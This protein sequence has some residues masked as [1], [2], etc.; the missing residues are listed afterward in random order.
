M[1]NT[2]SWLGQLTCDGPMFPVGQAAPPCAIIWDCAAACCAICNKKVTGM[3]A[4]DNHIC[5]KQIQTD[6][7]RTLWKSLDDYKADNCS[8][9]KSRAKYCR[10]KMHKYNH[11]CWIPNCRYYR[12]IS[13]EFQAWIWV[14]SEGFQCITQKSCRR[15]LIQIL[16]SLYDL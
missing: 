7:R 4:N 5:K 12:R 2:Q 13:V 11:S 1:H 16:H 6:G 15:L 9:L 8:D 14:D 3:I 10:N